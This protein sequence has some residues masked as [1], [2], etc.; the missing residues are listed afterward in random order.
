MDIVMFCPRCGTRREPQMGFCTR[1]GTNLGE[2]EEAI[3]RGTAAGAGIRLVRGAGGE[4]AAKRSRPARSPDQVTQGFPRVRRPQAEARET[5]PTGSSVWHPDAAGTE[6][7]GPVQ[8]GGARAPWIRKAGPSA[9]AFGFRP[10]AT[11]GAAMAVVSAFLPWMR[12]GSN[13]SAFDFPVRF[14]VTGEIGQRMVSVGAILAGLAGLALLLSVVHRLAL[15]RRFVGL[16][17]LA[18]P[19]L[20]A[21]VGLAPADLSQLFHE[22][23][24]G[25]YVAAVGG[26]LLAFG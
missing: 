19:V 20:F 26:L 14:L 7:V 9:M 1:C 17:V 18:V 21:I 15:L 23:G 10:F 22:L 12:S 16:M 6:R 8:H 11:L 4:Q 13:R 25:A 3:R 5:S 2:L 24:L